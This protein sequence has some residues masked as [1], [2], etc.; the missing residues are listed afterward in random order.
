MDGFTK[1]ALAVI[2]AALVVIAIQ[3]AIPSAS[4]QMVS[5]GSPSVPCYVTSRP[6]EAVWVEMVP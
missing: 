5:C 6:S 1:G 3:G 2:A 4:A